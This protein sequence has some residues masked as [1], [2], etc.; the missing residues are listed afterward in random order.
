MFHRLMVSAAL[1]MALGLPA[2]ADDATQ[3]ETGADP[4]VTVSQPTEDQAQ[5]VPS[6]TEPSTDAASSEV[7]P[8]QPRV[9]TQEDRS[10]AV[11]EQILNDTSTVI[12]G[13]AG[14]MIQTYGASMPRL[15]CKVYNICILELEPGETMVDTLSVGDNLRWQIFPRTNA[16]L[17]GRILQQFLFIKPDEQA[18]ESTLAFVTDRRVYSILLVPSDT[19]HTPRFAF[20]YPDTEAR[21][22]EEQLAADRAARLADRAA[23]AARRQNAIQTRGVQTASGAIPA[24]ELTFFTSITGRADFTPERVY[25]DGSKTY[26]QL[27]QGYRGEVPTPII[28]GG[29]NNQT[30]NVNYDASKRMMIIDRAVSDLRLSVGNDTVRVR[31]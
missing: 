29:N 2:V 14:L 1:A 22:L 7:A 15:I 28:S 16:D 26:I 17:D 21:E 4:D 8:D 13:E 12:Q 10:A 27:P 6:A 9:M 30:Y 20:R 31:R 23:S 19:L 5:E 25:T 24:E 11:A 3:N 18:V